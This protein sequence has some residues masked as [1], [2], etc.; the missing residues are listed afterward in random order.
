MRNLTAISLALAL[1]ACAAPGRGYWDHAD[2]DPAKF[3]QARAQCLYESAAATANAPAT[4]SLGQNIAQDIATG[5]RRG[6]LLVLC[7]QAKGYYF[8]PVP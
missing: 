3:D 1:S 2:K 4:F 8:V 6:E 5:T 7:L